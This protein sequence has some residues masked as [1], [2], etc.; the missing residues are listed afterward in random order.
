MQPCN[1][2]WKAAELTLQ[3]QRR[4]NTPQIQQSKSAKGIY[5]LPLILPWGVSVHY[6]YIS[7]LIEVGDI[8][9]KQGQIKVVVEI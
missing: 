3:K 1:R 5:S 8:P 7:S 2:E 4:E 9:A 6:T